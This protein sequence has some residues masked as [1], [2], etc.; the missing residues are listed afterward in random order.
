MQ[1]AG[2]TKIECPHFRLAIQNNPPRVDVYEPG[3]VPAE[4]MTQP[5]APPPEPNKAAIAGAL[6]A[7]IEVAGARLVQGQ[8]LVV[9]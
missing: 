4:F 9:S 1:V 8:R 6:K 5:V 3:L 2:V 7:G